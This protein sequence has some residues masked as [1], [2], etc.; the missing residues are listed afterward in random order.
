MHLSQ[1]KEFGCP[2]IR[3]CPSAHVINTGLLMR[4]EL[5]SMI[6]MTKAGM[7]NVTLHLI[8]N[9]EGGNK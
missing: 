5:E 7:I 6:R 8:T 2:E 4:S 1:S 3:E 9:Q